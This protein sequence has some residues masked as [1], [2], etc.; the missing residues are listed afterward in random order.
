MIGNMTDLIVRI[1]HTLNRKWVKWPLLV[2]FTVAILIAH[3]VMYMKYG[4]TPE[5]P[6]VQL[7]ITLHS[8][9]LVGIVLLVL[10]YK[11]YYKEK[12]IE[13]EREINCKD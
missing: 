2:V 9:M 4:G 1:L 11:R 5:S 13:Y 3:V 6:S 7:T 8:A 12:L 10:I